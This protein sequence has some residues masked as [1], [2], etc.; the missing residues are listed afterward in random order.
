MGARI[1][2]NHQVS[3]LN[4]GQMP[5]DSEFIVVFAEAAH[6]IVDVIA[7]MV[8]FPCH[9]NGGRIHTWPGA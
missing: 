9:R 8:F 2:D 3:L 6:N 4:S 5:V 1:V 7:G